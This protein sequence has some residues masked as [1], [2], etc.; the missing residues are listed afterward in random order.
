MVDSKISPRDMQLLRRQKY[1]SL[2]NYR[3]QS[4]F[5]TE[6]ENDNSEDESK[7]DNNN[8]NNKNNNNDSL[9]DSLKSMLDEDN[10]E[11]ETMLYDIRKELKN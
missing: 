9:V 8:E 11:E 7:S 1:S 10:E 6:E 5:N 4:D 3:E 2:S